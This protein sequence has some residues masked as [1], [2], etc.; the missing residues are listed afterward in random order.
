MKFIDFLE[1]VIPKKFK[2]KEIII[3]GNVL[4]E[5]YLKALA[6]NIATSYIASGFCKCEFKVYENSKEVKNKDYFKL[7]YSPNVNET[8]SKFWFK[9]VKKMLCEKEALVIE[10]NGN[11]YCVDSYTTEEFPMLGDKYKNIKLGSLTLNK[12][13]NANEVFIFKLEDEDIK[14]LIDGFYSSL[15]KV[16]SHAMDQYKRSNQEKYKLKIASVKAGDEDFNK[17][18]EEIIKKQLSE[19][20]NNDKAVYPEFEGY[21]L[22]SLSANTKISSKDSKDIIE[23]KKVIFDTIGQTY[24]LPK[25]LLDGNITNLNEVI[26]SIITF[27]I[28]PLATTVSQ[29]LSRKKG[30]DY[31]SKGNYVAVDTSTVNHIDTF[32]VAE[33][34]DKLI[35]SGA[36]CVDEIR[37]AI[38]KQPLGTD[39]STTHWI[40]KNYDTAE[41][42]LK[43]GENNE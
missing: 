31:W 42:S 14:K 3:T 6:I 11:L 37:E 13:Y 39:F 2:A 41:N 17:E 40:T 23:L 43:G 33:K 12:T 21:E 18:F 1:K 27:S 26:R 19:F 35:A 15:G 36:L 29:E 20:L 24:K 8:A 7:N 4:E 32:D 22:T 34:I 9:V 10:S 38:G 28:D 5:I 30:Y 25:S 16:L